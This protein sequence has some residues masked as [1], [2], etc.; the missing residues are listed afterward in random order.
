MAAWP[1]VRP[2]TQAAV[3]RMPSRVPET[4]ITPAVAAAPTAA[5][6]ARA[7]I[8]KGSIWLRAAF[9]ARHSPTRL[10]G[11]QWAAAVARADATT[12]PATTWPVPEP[13]AVA[14]S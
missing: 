8:A 14:L 3:V 10:T 2:V 13:R 7:A 5:L 6:A 9:R 12:L 11:L 1:V 4:R